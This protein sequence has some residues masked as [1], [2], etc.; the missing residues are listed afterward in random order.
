M[1]EIRI[2]MLGMV[3]GNGHPYSWSAIINGYDPVH[4]VD[5]P[6]PGILDYLR[7][8]PPETFGIEG[9]QVTHVW[10]D[11]PED[12][13]RV[14]R[15]ARI[16]HVVASPLDAIGEIDAAIIATDDGDG[17]LERCR[18]F[19]EAGIPVFIDKP[20]TLHKQHLERFVRWE[21]EGRRIL[22]SSGTR[23]GKE[24]APF[25]LSTANLGEVRLATVTTH[26]SWER[27]GIHALEA[28]YP[29]LGP[30]FESVRFVGRPEDTDRSLMLLRH[31]SGTEVLIIAI[32]D[33]L[34]SFGCLNLYGTRSHSHAQF[35]DTFYAF[36]SQ[37]TDFV[38][39]VRTGEPPFSFAE[40][41][42]L[43][44][45]LMGGVQSR[46]SGGVTVSLPG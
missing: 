4:E 17:H 28:V 38:R 46:E 26:R 37:L 41:V 7:P 45:I 2:A 1:N 29:I 34:G 13:E 23:Y 32:E 43:M 20:L 35:S 10:T 15:F 30:G 21:R 44:E 5:C 36:K 24:F 3:E 25:R 27:Y 14:A 12:G 42:E 40:T 6:Y 22:S 9:A 39:Y 31:R 16:P 11:R 8:Q 19:V 18:P 33:M